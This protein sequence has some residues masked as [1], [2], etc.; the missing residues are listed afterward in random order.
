MR[1]GLRSLGYS[2]LESPTGILPII[3]GD[4]AEAIRLSNQLLTMG[5]FVIGFGFP[6][7]PEGT[8]RLRV[9]MSAAHTDEHIDRALAAFAKLRS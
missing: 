6:V 4:T 9:Q 1:S 5:V 8:A 3:I 7:V 2:V